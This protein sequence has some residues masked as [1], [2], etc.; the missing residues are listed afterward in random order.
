MIVWQGKSVIPL[1]NTVYNYMLCYGFMCVRVRI[2]VCEVRMQLTHYNLTFVPLVSL[3]RL[4]NQ[5]CTYV[6]ASVDYCSHF[7]GF[8]GYQQAMSQSTLNW[9]CE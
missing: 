8:L 9:V 7:N 4:P 3:T 6:S 2:L 5:N 1:E